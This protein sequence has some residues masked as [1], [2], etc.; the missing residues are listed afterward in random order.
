[1]VEEIQK[2]IKDIEGKIEKAKESQLRIETEL[3]EY[4]RPI[5]VE[6]FDDYQY[7]LGFKMTYL[8]EI[9]I[10]TYMLILLKNIIKD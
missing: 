8:G 10:L 5:K 7:L 1:M 3:K 9:R 6:D 4:K 2:L